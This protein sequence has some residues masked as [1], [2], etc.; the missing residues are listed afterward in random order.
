MF[1]AILANKDDQGYRAEVAQVDEA[2]HPGW[3]RSHQGVVFHAKL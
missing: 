2:S 3:R 1:K